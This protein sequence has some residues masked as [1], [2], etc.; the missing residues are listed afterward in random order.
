M[1]ESTAHFRLGPMHRAG[2]VSSQTPL[3]AVVGR[4]APL[5]CS[6]GD[7]DSQ[8]V[9]FK[10]HRQRRMMIYESALLRKLFKELQRVV[11]LHATSVGSE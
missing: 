7:V 8:S 9:S 1:S 2:T 3:N 11:A 4:P 10:N 6:T 5:R